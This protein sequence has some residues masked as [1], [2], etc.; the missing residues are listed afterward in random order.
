MGGMGIRRYR[1]ADLPALRDVCVR[2][3]HQGEDATGRYRDPSL[4]PAA[5][6]DPYLLL[7]PDLAFVLDAGG[8]AAGYVVGTADTAAFI[9]RYRADYLPVLADRTAE[10]G[11]PD[12]EVL[13]AA[14]APERMS[15]PDLAD[16]PAHL[17]INLLPAH[18]G[19]GHGRALM[20]AFLHALAERGVGAVHLGMAAANHRARAFYLRMGFHEV[21]VAGVDSGTTHFARGL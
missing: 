6:L 12:E 4:L 16:Y 2:T 13:A 20:G 19:A 10:P 11:T 7:E 21:A 17:H 5:Y 1:P 3:G 14:R 8:G 18:Q 9:R 15:A